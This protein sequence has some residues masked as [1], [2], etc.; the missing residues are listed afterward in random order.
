[1][2]PSTI[3]RRISS[4]SRVSS[5]ELR[6][7]KNAS[8]PQWRAGK[9][10]DGTA[11]VLPISSSS[12]IE[13]QKKA[14]LCAVT[15]KAS[16]GGTSPFTSTTSQKSLCRPC[17]TSSTTLPKLV[18][19]ALLPHGNRKTERLLDGEGL[20]V[21]KEGITVEWASRLEHRVITSRSSP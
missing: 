15:F 8:N 5:E 3:I 21:A 12:Q 17:R 9:T 20:T 13:V 6:R 19:S 7:A 1:M 10:W 2:L 11:S 16:E 18:P 4:H 14:Q